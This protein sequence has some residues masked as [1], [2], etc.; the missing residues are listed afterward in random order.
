MSVVIVSV[1]GRHCLMHSVLSSAS[2][3]Q[4]AGV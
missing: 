4:T 2:I 3:V 1:L